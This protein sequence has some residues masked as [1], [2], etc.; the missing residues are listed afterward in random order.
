MEFHKSDASE[1][2]TKLTATAVILGVTAGEQVDF[3]DIAVVGQFQA[4][5][6][7]LVACDLR[8]GSDGRETHTQSH[9]VVA[10][11]AVIATTLDVE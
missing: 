5:L 9:L 4:V 1:G 7:V 11:H 10:G 6:Q 3:I 2:G 8:E